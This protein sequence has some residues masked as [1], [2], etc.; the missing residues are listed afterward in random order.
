MAEVGCETITLTPEAQE[1]F[2][3]VAEG[4]WPNYVGEGKLV[5]QEL[6]NKI[7]EIGKD[8]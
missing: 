3:A 5:S 6:F 8:F 2:Y 7:V 1:E 4:L